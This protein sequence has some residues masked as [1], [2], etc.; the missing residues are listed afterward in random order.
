MLTQRGI[1]GEDMI[2]EIHSNI[3]RMDIND[4][5]KLLLIEKIGEYEFRLTEGSDAK[6]QLEALLAQIALI[7]NK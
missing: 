3:L 2:K 6:I 4:H 1:A 7:G 5:K